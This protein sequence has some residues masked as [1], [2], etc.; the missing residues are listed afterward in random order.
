MSLLE[1]LISATKGL[2][3]LAFIYEIRNQYEWALSHLK[4]VMNRYI[5]SDEP[6]L[7]NDRGPRYLL[8]FW[9]ITYFQNIF[10]NIQSTICP[11]YANFVNYTK[12]ISMYLPAKITTDCL[13]VFHTA[14]GSVL[15]D[16]F[17]ALWVLFRFPLSLS[18]FSLFTPTC[19]RSF[20]QPHLTI[21][22]FY[23]G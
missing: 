7:R 21:S 2:L 11:T 16:P 18:I 23:S 15:S 13:T 10:S 19:L 6:F 3:V 1:L 5:L 17:T 22:H 14:I 8:T 4:S 9:P 20:H 12:A